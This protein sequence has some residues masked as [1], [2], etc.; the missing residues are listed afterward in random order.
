MDKQ[1]LDKQKYFYLTTRG[2][3]SGARHEIEIWFVE[4]EGCYF[5]V[6]E[7]REAAH[8]VRNIRADSAVRFRIGYAWD[9]DDAVATEGSASFPVEPALIDAVKAKMDAKYGWS[10]GLVVA[11]CG[12]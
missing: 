6:S 1:A 12:N 10:N 3:R 5:L 9:D 8:W 11:I 2:H 4:H 7:K